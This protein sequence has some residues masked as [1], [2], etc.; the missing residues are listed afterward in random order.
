LDTGGRVESVKGELSYGTGTRGTGLGKV[1]KPPRTGGRRNRPTLIQKR[2]GS[3]E[4]ISSTIKA[5][6]NSI[7]VRKLRRNDFG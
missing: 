2:K 6:E 1:G 3:G 4:E 5:E 7:S